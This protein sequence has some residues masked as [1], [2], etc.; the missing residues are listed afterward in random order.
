MNNQIIEAYLNEHNKL[1]GSN[2]VNWKFKMQILLEVQSAW[3]IANGDEQKPAPGSASIP[4][5]E[6]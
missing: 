2:Y 1:D 6:K 4:N 3:T 5:W